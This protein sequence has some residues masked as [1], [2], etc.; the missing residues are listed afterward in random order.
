VTIFPASFIKNDMANMGVSSG[1]SGTRTYRYYSNEFG[2]PLFE[3]GSG[4]SLT[5]FTMQAGPAPP[6][7]EV[8]SVNQNGSMEVVV[9]NTGSREGDAVVLFFWSGPP[10]KI[11][12]PIGMPIP[13]RKL[14]GFNRVS[15]EAGA[16]ATITFTATAESLALVDDNGDTQLFAGN[17]VVQASLGSGPSHEVGFTVK[18]QTMIRELIW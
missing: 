4:L 8:V 1:D 5:P 17:H 7:P 15:L 9:S 13:T 6:A 16:S 11:T 2:A 3:F 14:V 12:T 10:S 18:S